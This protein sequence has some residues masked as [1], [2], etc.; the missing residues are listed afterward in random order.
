MFFT[1]YY[2]PEHTGQDQIDTK[3]LEKIKLI[4]IRK[5]CRVG[6]GLIIVNK[7]IKETKKKKMIFF[8]SVRSNFISLITSKLVFLLFLAKECAHCW[9]TA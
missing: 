7:S 9:L 5:C 2:A 6:I 1:Q 4:S 3:W 8:F